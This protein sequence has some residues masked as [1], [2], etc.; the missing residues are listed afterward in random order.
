MT[1]VEGG[2]VLTSLMMWL[3]RAFSGFSG[4]CTEM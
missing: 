1:D 4:A 3:Q 2:A